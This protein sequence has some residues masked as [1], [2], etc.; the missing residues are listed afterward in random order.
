M[1]LPTGCFPQEFEEAAI[2]PLLKK[3]RLDANELRNYRP[4]SNLQ[5][6]SKL[7]A[8]VVQVRMQA[9]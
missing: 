4:L 2:R 9:F 1:S 7:L 6:L 8:K 5:F 3:S